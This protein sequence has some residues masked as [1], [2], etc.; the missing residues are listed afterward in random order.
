MKKEIIGI[1]SGR[2]SLLKPEYRQKK[3]SEGLASVAVYKTDTKHGLRAEI[4]NWHYFYEKTLFPKF[5][6]KEREAHKKHLAKCDRE[7]EKAKKLGK[8]WPDTSKW[9][10][11]DKESLLRETAFHLVMLEL[12]EK[13]NN[14]YLIHSSKAETLYSA[15]HS[16]SPENPQTL[17]NYAVGMGT[18]MLEAMQVLNMPFAKEYYN[19][20]FPKKRKVSWD[21]TFKRGWTWYYKAVAYIVK[22]IYKPLG[23][24]AVE[25]YK[26][27]AKK[28]EKKIGKKEAEK[29]R[30]EIS[31][32][33]NRRRKYDK[34]IKDIKEKYGVKRD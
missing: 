10:Y 28:Q 8:P 30:K 26:E 17:T 31:D 34:I 15:I 12:L 7:E 21:V 27:H 14:E 32:W 22:I 25:K 2:Q 19:I 16:H 5:T 13:E 18:P 4:H 20:L 1:W 33:K 9:V 6:K 24:Q 23:K 29:I 3:D 11:P